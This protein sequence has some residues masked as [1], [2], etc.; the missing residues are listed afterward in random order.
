MWLLPAF[1]LLSS[2][3][4][5][6]YYRLRMAG[7]GVP[8]TG[9]VLLVANHPNSLL[10]PILVCA[11]ARR[12]VRFLAKA[13]L[14]THPIWGWM[15]RGVG[16][17]P[18]Y[19]RMDDPTVS[20]RNVDMFRAVFDELSK[21]AA[22]GIFPEGV[23]HSE[24]SL[25]TLKT[26][27]ARIALG[28]FEKQPRVFPIIPIGLV[29][30]QK[31]VFRSEAM[32]VLG[33]PVAWDDLAP[34]GWEDKEAVRKLTARIEDGLRSVTVNVERWEDKP[35]IECAEAI[36][37][38]EWGADGDPAGRIAR[39]HVTTTIL[40]QLRRD[41]EMQWSSLVRDVSA[42]F[43]RLR[44]LGLR[45]VHLRADVRLR[46]SISWTVRRLYLLGLP[47]IALAVAGH[48]LLWAPYQLTHLVTTGAPAQPLEDRRSTFKLFIGIASYA[49][50]ILL[51]AAAAGW[52]GGPLIGV[53]ALFVIPLVGLLGRR[54]RERWGSAWHDARRF[55][56]L[57]SRKQ[58]METLRER[59]RDL[60][61]RL[62]AL[63][64]TL[65]ARPEGRV[66]SP[67]DASL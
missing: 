50:W 38:A 28:T 32:V 29:F 22:I 12:P 39:L 66:R 34:R 7:E 16:A 5:R 2:A 33:R 64:E 20:E 19:R 31:D 65:E 18:V 13:Q 3:A 41:P 52:I 47:A 14:F 10:D 61:V 17:I 8:R 21:G 60:A 25:V 6:I 57:R 9:P 42:H 15:M 46:T 55:F 49:L 1:S 54:I 43:R 4:G 44:V 23:S 27:A 45:P 26:G 35:L 62:K 36:W 40:A 59:Q 11:V 63:Y 37:S 30:R 67:N 58:L 51:L 53:G 56:L 48:V 24:P